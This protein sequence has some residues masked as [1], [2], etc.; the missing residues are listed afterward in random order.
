M[1]LQ[2]GKEH[3]FRSYAH[4]YDLRHLL[5][6][7]PP[8]T[9]HQGRLATADPALPAGLKS[10]ESQDLPGL[11]MRRLFSLSLRLVAQIVPSSS[12]PQPPSL[13][14]PSPAAGLWA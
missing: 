7:Q 13:S 4:P 6:S 10:C 5:P 14:G 8:L 1:A 12:P 3:I 2:S 9:R 11:D